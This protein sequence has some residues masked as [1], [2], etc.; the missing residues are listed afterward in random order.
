MVTFT[1]TCTAAVGRGGGGDLGGGV[2]RVGGG[3]DAP[4]GDGARAVRAPGE[5]GAGDDDRGAAGQRAAR[6]ELRPVMVGAAT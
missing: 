1:C 6:W 3:V 5:V 4:E 2:D